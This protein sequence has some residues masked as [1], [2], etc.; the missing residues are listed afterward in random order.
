[1]TIRTKCE[2]C[3]GIL[4]NIYK[5]ENVPVNLSCIEFE[6]D[7]FFD[8]LSFSQCLTCNT[9]Q[10][11]KLI[12]LNILYETSHN[13]SSVGKIWENYF[14]LLIKKI[15]SI[16]APLNN[17]NWTSTQ[18]IQG[19]QLPINKTV[20]EI[21]CPSG[22]IA[23]NCYD[24]EKWY[25]VE[26]NKNNKIVFNDKIFF[27]ES[28]FNENLTIDKPIDLIVHS[29]VFEH[30]YEPNKFL[31]KCYELLT[32]NGVMV[33]GIPNMQHLAE[34][35]LS[36]FLGMFFEHTI[37]LNK[38]NVSYLMKKN[39]FAILEI[40]D[41]ENHSTIYHVKKVRVETINIIP[42]IKI[43]N[44][45]DI[46]FNLINEYKSFIEK[47][48]KTIS[49]NPTKDIYIFGASYN[50][51]IIL[52]FDFKPELL[53]GVLDNCKEKQN[54]YLYGS[55]LKIYSPEIVNN[56]TIVILKNGYYVNEICYQIQEINENVIIIS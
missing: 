41:Y 40:I 1:M 17:S 19:L 13:Y 56:N 30:I 53:K 45:Y 10:L 3:N 18:D 36:L 16:I 4:N 51:Q 34:N 29:H 22:K 37:F 11:D 32:E 12:P 14:I 21:G 48:N 7:C 35:S 54:K 24:Y 50:T 49:N 8:T 23:L 2:I 26:P 42:V 52:S 44:Y 38:E 55:K 46:F 9:I 27:I 6:N 5:L 33:F 20:L 47:C 39:G 31:K 43:T 25:I 28:F 15:Q